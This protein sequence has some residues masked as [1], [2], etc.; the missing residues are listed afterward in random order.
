MND[1]Y[2][3]TSGSLPSA[4]PAPPPYYTHQ[5]NENEF[6]FKYQSHRKNS[7]FLK[8]EI[9]N[10]KCGALYTQRRLTNT[11]RKRVSFKYQNK[12]MKT[13]QHHEWITEQ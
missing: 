4:L 8:K 2:V 1:I 13:D 12:R 10:G 6:G 9:E 5:Y 3:R 11:H 7:I